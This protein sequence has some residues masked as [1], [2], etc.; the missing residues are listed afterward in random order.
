MLER[1]ALAQHDL[2]SRFVQNGA[3]PPPTDSVDDLRFGAV[4]EQHQRAQM[5]H[6]AA[7]PP[8]SVGYEEDVQRVET[9]VARDPHDDAV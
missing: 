3:R 2:V 9:D 1:R 8:P 5:G 7:C 4:L 6:C